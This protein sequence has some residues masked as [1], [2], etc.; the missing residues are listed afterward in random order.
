MDNLDTIQNEEI[1][2]IKDIRTI[3]IIWIR[4]NIKASNR[5]SDVQSNKTSQG[6]T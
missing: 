4:Y 2:T 6:V 5:Y 3:C 1:E